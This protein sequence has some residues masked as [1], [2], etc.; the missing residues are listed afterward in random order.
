MVRVVAGL[1]R[2]HGRILI[3]QRGRGGEHPGQ[4]EFPGGKL[5]PGE[6]ER[7]A[8][9]REL[10]EEL[11]IEAKLGRLEARVRHTYAAG[12][13]VEVAFYQ[14]DGFDP[15]PENRVFQAMVWAAPGE[16]HGYDFLAADH[17]VLERLQA[18]LD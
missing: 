6:E 3:C 7:A 15:E 17:G 1:L 2:R 18:M 10:R 9:V 13:E 14:V 4:W 8:L 16:L 5:E 11:G 12:R